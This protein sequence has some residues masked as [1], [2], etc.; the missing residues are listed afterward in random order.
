LISLKAEWALSGDLYFLERAGLLNGAQ[1]GD[2]RIEEVQ[3][4]QANVLVEVQFTV[5]STVSAAAVVM[6][7]GQHG[8]HQ[9]EM[10]ETMQ[11]FF[12]DFG[13]LRRAHVALSMR[14]EPAAR[15]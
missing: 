10:L 4:N 15:K 3:Q 11:I 1:A 9:F 14:H 7:L 12:F 5:A 8:Q 2:D 13:S 6:K